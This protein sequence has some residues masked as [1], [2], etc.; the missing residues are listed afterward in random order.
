MKY[1]LLRVRVVVRTSNMKISHRHL[2][3]CVK[4]KSTIRRGARTAPLFFLIQPLWPCRGRCRRHYLNSLVSP[5]GQ[6]DTRR[7]YWYLLVPFP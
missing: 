3:D 5:K 6:V 2:V 7:R 4:K 1:L